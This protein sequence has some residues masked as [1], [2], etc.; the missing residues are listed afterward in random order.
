MLHKI[1]LS[2]LHFSKITNYTGITK[3]FTCAIDSNDKL[4]SISSVTVVH[5]C[6][7]YIL[8]HF[9]LEKFYSAK[10]GAMGIVN[11]ILKPT[12][13]LENELYI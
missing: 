10:T 9:S 12:L 13:E 4:T 8:F 5:I 11:K 2:Y 3:T 1:N 6:N 7:I